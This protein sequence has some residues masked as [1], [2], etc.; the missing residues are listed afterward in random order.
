M[1]GDIVSKIFFILAVLFVTGILLMMI[2]AIVSLPSVVS[3]DKQCLEY[4]FPRSNVTWP[5][6]QYC[7]RIVD[8]TEYMCLLSDVKAGTCI[9]PGGE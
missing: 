6:V 8:A 3:A 5:F 1:V 2:L 9:I 4:G 7:M